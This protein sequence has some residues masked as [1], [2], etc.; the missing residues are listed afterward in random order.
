MVNPYWLV[1]CQGGALLIHK[2]YEAPRFLT[3][4]STQRWNPS[5]IIWSFPKIGVPPNHPNF[6]GI[7]HE[8]NQPAFLGY[9]HDSGTP[10]FFSLVE[11]HHAAP[12]GPTFGDSEDQTSGRQVRARDIFWALGES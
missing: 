4:G 3:E 7:F 1:D 5:M 10:L 2:L 6:S 12:L 9:P 11:N 8:K